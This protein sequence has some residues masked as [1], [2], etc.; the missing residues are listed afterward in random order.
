MLTTAQPITHFFTKVVGVTHPNSD[1]SDRQEIIQGCKPCE[2]VF[3]RPEPENPF[4]P[5]AIAVDREQGEQL[6]YL[7]AGLA[8]E[9]KQDCEH[10]AFIW[11]VLGGEGGF[12]TLGVQLVVIRAEEGV[13]P[14][15]IQEY[16]DS[17][18]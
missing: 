3:L 10:I 9:L 7:P 15:E 8:K 11:A 17:S 5:N 12:S 2:Q 16:I 1:G 13:T 18:V 6:G 14:E 4:D